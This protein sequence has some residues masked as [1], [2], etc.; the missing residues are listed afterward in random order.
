MN[1]VKKRNRETHEREGEKDSCIHTT[2]TSRAFFFFLANF[3]FASKN[4]K[5]EVAWIEGAHI[6][7]EP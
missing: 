4:H 2:V 7:N 6:Y 5:Q 1:T 3:G